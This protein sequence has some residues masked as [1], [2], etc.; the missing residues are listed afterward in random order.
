[1]PANQG[2]HLKILHVLRAPVGGLFRHVVDLARGQAA[3][4]H[5]VGVIADS[6]TG[7]AQA[8]AVLAVLAPNLT[9]GVSRT[10][11]SRH[12]GLRDIA[13]LRGVVR[14]IAEAEADVVHGHGAKGGAYARLAGGRGG[15]DVRAYTP[16]GG[17]LHYP[18]TS[19]AGFFYLAAER[20]LMRRTDLFLFESRYGRDVF[21][22]K[23][24]R[25]H[26]VVR[27]V[28]NGVTAAEVA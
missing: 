6:S 7:G 19:P 11:M 3:R 22:A 25:P 17:S 18:W 13:A 1:M 10:P 16:H 5:R 14:R 15:R 12:V 9:L 27:V 21:Q 23:I 8:D 26:A 20:A 2:K 24:G 28:H 4:G